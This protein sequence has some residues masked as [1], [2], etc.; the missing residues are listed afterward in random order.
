MSEIIQSLKTIA[1]RVFEIGSKQGDLNSLQTDNKTDFVA[2]LNEL[3]ARP[4]SGLTE[5]RA[6]EIARETAQGEV[7]AEIGKLTEGANEALDTF[8][9]IGD[10]LKLG[11]DAAAAVLEEIG[12]LKTRLTALEAYTGIAEKDELNNTVTRLLNGSEQ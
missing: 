4:S 6:R 10:K 3:H 8:K 2:A 7:S 5:E 12:R 11:D 9:E 1:R